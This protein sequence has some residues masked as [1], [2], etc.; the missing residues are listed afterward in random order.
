MRKIAAMVIMIVMILPVLC[1]LPVN[2]VKAKS[3]KADVGSGGFVDIT[4]YLHNDSTLDTIEPTSENV[5]IKK[6]KDG[7]FDFKTEYLLTNLNVGGV[8]ITIEFWVDLYFVLGTLYPPKKGSANV[9][10]TFSIYDHNKKINDNSWVKNSGEIRGEWSYTTPKDSPDTVQIDLSSWDEKQFDDTVKLV[11]T[12]TIDTT[13]EQEDLRRDDF[14]F[15][16]TDYP[17]SLQIRCAPVEIDV[18]TYYKNDTLGTKFMPNLATE[19]CI[20]K[21]K[22][23]IEDAFGD[24]DITHVSMEIK[25]TNVFHSVNNITENKTKPLLYE[26]DYSKYSTKFVA[27]TP[28]IATITVETVQLHTFTKTTNFTFKAYGLEAKIDND[29]SASETITAGNQTDYIISIRNTGASEA[30]VN[31][32]LSIFV[33]PSG[34]HSWNISLNGK[35][36][37]VNT[38]GNLLYP[39][40][41]LTG[42]YT[43]SLIL[44]TNSLNVTGEVGDDWECIIN[45]KVKF[46]TEETGLLLATTVLAPPHKIDINWTNTLDDPYYV[47]VD[48][49]SS[50]SID[51]TNM[52]S[53]PDTVD[54]TLNYTNYGVWD[55]TFKNGWKNTTTEKLNP[56]RYTLGGY[57]EEVKLIIIASSEGENEATI[58]VNIIAC[59]QGNKSVRD[60][61]TLNLSRA[62]GITMD[63]ELKGTGEADVKDSDG[64]AIYEVSIKTN[65]NTTHTVD[66]NAVCNN[67]NIDVGFDDDSVAV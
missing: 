60:Y 46:G 19:D 47:L 21:F 31:V 12:P 32:T 30:T 29:V 55:I 11:I 8:N 18:S 39:D 10:I 6:L 56:Y 51:V 25:G 22:G 48:V 40:F 38:T 43:K 7:A 37:E 27:D 1:L 41:K 33:S 63:V 35:S 66:L 42:G 36:K 17:S 58:S 4:L 52:G 53:L 2:D 44:T 50:L 16:S 61:L 34:Q 5:T 57:E 64:E 59:S 9:T 3:M 49:S 15:D 23:G 62:F 20:I 14:Y 26:W 45:I 28:Y 54:L 13:N 67:E 65:D 24:D